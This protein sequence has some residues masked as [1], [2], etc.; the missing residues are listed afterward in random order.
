MSISIATV[1]QFATSDGLGWE[2]QT[3]KAGQEGN[4]LVQE[5]CSFYRWGGGRGHLAEKATG[6]RQQ[7]FTWKRSLQN[8][9]WL[10]PH[11]TSLK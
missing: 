5:C 2:P 7:T 9:L 1:S 6:K 10:K 11:T 4:L 3:L 8:L